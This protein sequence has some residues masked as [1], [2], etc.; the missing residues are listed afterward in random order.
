MSGHRAKR[1]LVLDDDGDVAAIIGELLADAGFETEVFSDPAAALARICREPQVHVAVVD[2]QMPVLSGADFIQSMRDA[3]AGVP[4]IL[5]TGDASVA[6]RDAALA[7]ACLRK[8]PNV[9]QLLE[10]V[11]N[12]AAQRRGVE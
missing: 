1:A 3:H 9:D 6:P 2:Y 11:T 4:A 12:A 8:P 10:V 5:L 7:A